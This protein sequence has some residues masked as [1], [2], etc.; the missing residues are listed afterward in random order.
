M[1]QQED[2]P[3][4][5][6]LASPVE[7]QP[8]ADNAAPK[9]WDWR[10]T[11]TSQPNAATFHVSHS[12]VGRVLVDSLQ[13]SDSPPDSPFV[14]SSEI[15]IIIMDSLDQYWAGESRTK[16]PLEGIRVPV[17]DETIKGSKQALAKD[18]AAQLRLLLLL[19]TSREGKIAPQLRSNLEYLQSVLSPRER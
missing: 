16:L 11:S 15:P 17:A 14:I 12:D 1:S 13:P 10:R 9:N 6:D 8:G 19:F 4:A 7:I 5:Q 2:R 3:L 18:L